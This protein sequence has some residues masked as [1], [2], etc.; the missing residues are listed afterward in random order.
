M[1]YGY[2]KGEFYGSLYQG[3]IAPSKVFG[4]LVEQNGVVTNP[5]VG[6]SINIDPE[7]SWNK[8][9]GWRG[10][11]LDN[12]IQGQLTYFHNASRNFYAGGRN[13]VFTEL[14]E[15]NVQGVEMA[16]NLELLNTNG[17]QLHFLGSNRTEA[18]TWVFLW[19]M[20]QRRLNLR[21][22]DRYI[23]Q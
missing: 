14:G 10:G 16:I 8:E 9:I 11:L 12:F 18:G 6:Q 19:T 3:M 22:F 4:F 20:P 2:G 13:E 15:I 5:L 7:L 21:R 1:D 17:H 23:Y